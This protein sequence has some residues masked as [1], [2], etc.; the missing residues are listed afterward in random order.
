M[1]KVEG[2]LLSEGVEKLLEFEGMGEVE[3]TVESDVFDRLGTPRILQKDARGCERW[4][5]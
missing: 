2:M 3:R 5:G 4:L 1:V